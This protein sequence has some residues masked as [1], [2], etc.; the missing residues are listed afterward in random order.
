MSGEHEIAIFY[1]GSLVLGGRTVLRGYASRYSRIDVYARVILAVA[2]LGADWPVH[3][4][5]RVNG[6]PFRLTAKPSCYKGRGE[7]G[8]VYSVLAALRRGQHE[9]IVAEREHY[10]R[11]LH[12]YSKTRVIVRLSEAGED[13]SGILLRGRTLWVMGAHKEPE[14]S[15][16]NIIRRY[17]SQEVSIGPLSYLSSQTAAYIVWRLSW[18]D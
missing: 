15:I 7:R 6:E 16:E 2:S 3:A 8:V 4:L 5:V 17:A 14:E 12:R 9:C 18:R 13:V 1:P 11:F 10:E